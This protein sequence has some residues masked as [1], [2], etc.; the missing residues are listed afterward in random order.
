MKRALIATRDASFKDKMSEHLNGRGYQ[1]MF[2][3]NCKDAFI[4]LIDNSYD[5]VVFDPNLKAMNGLDT[6][7][8]IEKILPE[9]PIVI[10]SDK[11]SYEMG[12]A[13]A[14]IGVYF[15]MSKSLDERITKELF[16]SLE[17]RFE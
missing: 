9:I 1:T 17:K 3:D 5:F 10:C 2:V 4:K 16:E 12:L 14:K 13:I 15:S 7:E 8:I 6:L 11:M